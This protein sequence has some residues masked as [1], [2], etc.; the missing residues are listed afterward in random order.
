MLPRLVN[1]VLGAIPDAKIADILRAEMGLI[2]TKRD[3]ALR[4]VADLEK[5]N[6]ALKQK[7]AELQA[8]VG[9]LEIEDAKHR[10]QIGDFEKAAAGAS[11]VCG[12]T[13][14]SRRSRSLDGL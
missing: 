12:A 1:A 7:V 9:T 13:R 2:T 14:R 5:E 11:F 3:V 8:R 4:K 6:A 10:Q